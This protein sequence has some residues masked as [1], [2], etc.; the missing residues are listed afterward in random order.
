MQLQAM[1]M[2]G[3]AFVDLISVIVPVYKVEDY[4]NRCI[5][6][7]VEQTYSQ[8]EIILV[9]DGSPDNCPFMCDAWAKKDDRIQVIHKKNGGLSDARNAGML[10]ASGK[11]IAFVD[12][13]DWIHSQYIELLYTAI[14]K[15]DADIAGCDIRWVYDD[16]IQCEHVSAMMESYTSEE[17]LET[18]IKGIGFRAVA[19]NKLYNRRLLQ[20]EYFAIGRYHEDEFFTYKILAKTER[21]AFVN[22]ELYFYFQREGSIMNSSSSKHLDVL[23]AYLERLAFLQNKYPVLYHVD[24]VGFCISCIGLYQDTL[25]FPGTEQK[26]CMGMIKNCRSKVHFG[27]KELFTYSCR[28]KVYIMGSGL[29]IDFMCRFLLLRRKNN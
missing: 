2:G 5:E 24:K 6:S 29:C 27:F 17:A 19:W 7:I 8:L 14:K 21:L 13:D 23:D 26:L 16:S 1:A 11:Y 3:G 28:E 25:R 12:S 9:D 20:D 18:L 15:Y 22:A 4:L 10:I